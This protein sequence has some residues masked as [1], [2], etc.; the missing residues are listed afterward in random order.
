M[1]SSNHAIID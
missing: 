1:D